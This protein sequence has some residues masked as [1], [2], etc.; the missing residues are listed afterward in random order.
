[1]SQWFNQLGADF[2]NWIDEAAADGRLHEW[3]ENAITAL[4]DLGSIIGSTAGILSAF[5][6]AALEA[7][8]PTLGNFA[9]GLEKVNE[10][11]NGPLWQGALTDVFRGANQGVE[12]MGQGVRELGDAFLNISG[13][14]EDVLGKAGEAASGF[15]ELV[16]DIV[17]QPA[18]TSGLTGF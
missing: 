2:K 12:N 18:F 5:S 4:K 13:V 1:M 6:K 3:I 10:A 8:G 17:Q 15:M 14:I 11:L 9:D 7:G 16:A